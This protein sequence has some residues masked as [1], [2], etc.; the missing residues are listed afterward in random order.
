VIVCGDCGRENDERAL[1]CENPACGALLEWSGKPVD[2]D[3]TKTEAP[4]EVMAQGGADAPAVPTPSP[5]SDEPRGP[6]ARKP[7][8]EFVPPPPRPRQEVPPAGIGYLVCPRCGTGNL[9]H[10]NFCRRCGLTLASAPVVMPTWWQRILR[11]RPPAR[12][13]ERRGWVRSRGRIRRDELTR[14]ALIGLAAVAVAA[15]VAL[16]GLLAWRAGA[17]D[18]A[19]DA[20][21][22]TRGFLFPR[23]EPVRP[24]AERASSAR[25]RRH[26]AD[27]AFDQDLNTFWLAGRRG[28][29]T[30]ARLVMRFEPETDLARMGVFVGDPVAKQL[31]PKRLQL[32]FFRRR[33]RPARGWEVVDIRNLDLENEPDFQR[34]DLDVENIQRLVMTIR[35][36][37]RSDSPRASAAIT[38]VEFFRRK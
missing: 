26:R 25:R 33:A 14:S 16:G 20:Y 28:G 36:T 31:V 7:A 5:P 4:T 21:E 1:F 35:K 8:P 29:G 18:A 13:G 9:P 19:V 2:P 6:T 24:V 17:K 15:V 12:A 22:S 32:T 11:R 37:Y 38:E 10:L 34:R 27:A 23:Y 30:G 3:A